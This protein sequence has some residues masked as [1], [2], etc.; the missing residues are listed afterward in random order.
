VKCRNIA[1]S[2]VCIHDIALFNVIRMSPQACKLDK[3]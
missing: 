1:G 2:T 3:N